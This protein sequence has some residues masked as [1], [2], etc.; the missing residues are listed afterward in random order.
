[1]VKVFLFT[2]L[3]VSSASAYPSSSCI[4]WFEDAK[5]DP[6]SKMCES[7]CSIAMVDMGTFMCHIEC[8]ELCNFKNAKGIANYV[9]YPGLTSAEK[10]LIDKYPKEALIVFIQKLNAESASSRNFPNQ[11]L[12]DEGDAFRHYLWAGL[13]TKELGAEMAK[14]FLDAHEANPL[15]TK[16]EKSMDLANNRGGILE[17]EK[18]Q[19]LNKLDQSNLEKKCLEDLRGDKLIVIKPGLTIPKEPL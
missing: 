8:A 17:A 6:N 15:Q 3:F 14:T 10:A 19:K 13:L 18:L 5:L 7:D 12:N 4:E 11:K 1:M 16:E 9:F 2:I